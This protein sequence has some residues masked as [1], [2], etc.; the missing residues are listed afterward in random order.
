MELCFKEGSDEIIDSDRLQV[1]GLLFS[2][3]KM[4]E[5]IPYILSGS[6]REKKADYQWMDRKTIS[7]LPPALY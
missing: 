1:I 5:Y 6:D 7:M 4:R 2:D 3:D